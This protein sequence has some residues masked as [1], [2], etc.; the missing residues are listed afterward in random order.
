[1]TVFTDVMLY[2]SAVFVGD[3]CLSVCLSQSNIVSE[4]LTL[5]FQVFH[6]S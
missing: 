2:L 6:N 1:L 4:Q 5:S 3:R